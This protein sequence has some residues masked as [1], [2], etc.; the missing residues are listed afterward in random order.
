MGN[1]TKY[2]I[3]ALIAGFTLCA[4]SAHRSPLDMEEMRRADLELQSIHDMVASRAIPPIEFEFNSST[5]LASS[6]DLLVRVAE[7]LRRHPTLKLIVEGHTDDV[8]GG[9]YNEILSLKR[10]GAVKQRLAEKGVYPDYVKVFGFG[11][12]RPL[13][14][15]TSDRGRALNR[16]VEF[17]ITTRDWESVY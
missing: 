6:D 2:S 4:C 10:A 15:D 9:E 17:I 11:K 7:I 3:A 13:T 1:K 8:G 14:N 16:R 5:L 12:S